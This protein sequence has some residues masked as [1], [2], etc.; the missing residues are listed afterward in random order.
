MLPIPGLP[1]AKLI[2]L[3]L[4]ILA[5]IAAFFWFRGVLNERAELRDWQEQVTVATRL[6]AD[7]PK[8]AKKDVAQ[9]VG[10]LGKAIADLKAGIANQ[11]AAINAHAEETKRQQE[12]SA[13]AQKRVLQR[14]ERAEATSRRLDASSRSSAATAK[15]CDP[16]ATL[17]EAWR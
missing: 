15:P 7:N 12:A 4:G 10:L 14:A 13:I 5:L 1:T 2:G 6:A 9:Q 11:N 16:S 8:L 17:T 3:G